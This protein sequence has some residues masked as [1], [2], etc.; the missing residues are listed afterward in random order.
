MTDRHAAIGELPHGRGVLGLLITDP[1][2]VRMPDI[3][4]HPRSFGFPPNHPPMHSFLGGPDP[5][6]AVG[7]RHP[8]DGAPVGSCHRDA[9]N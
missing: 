4:Q 8:L 9:P 1:S 7:V 3:T 6:R 5:C 2:A